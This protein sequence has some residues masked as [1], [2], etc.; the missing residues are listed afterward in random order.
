MASKNFYTGY[1]KSTRF[2]LYL[3]SSKDVANNRSLVKWYAYLEN[4]NY[5]YVNAIRINSVVVNGT[6]VCG[7]KT[8]SNYTSK[9]S[10]LLASGQLYVA[11][12]ADGNKQIS[13][14]I[15]GWL[16]SYGNKNA[17]GS[18]TL[19]SIPRATTPTLGA[20]SVSLGNAV[21]INTSPAV[22]SWTHTIKWKFGDQSGTIATK[23][24]AKSTSWTPPASL[25]SE[26]PDATTGTVT[27]TVE[28][29]NG[30]TLIGSKTINLKITVP[31]TS[32]TFKPT[33]SSVSMTEA[34]ESVTTMF[35]SI[36]VKLLSKVTFGITASGKYGSEIVAYK[37]VF[38]DVTYNSQSFTSNAIKASGTVTAT[39]TV[40]DSRGA[41][42]QTT[43]SITV[44]DY[45]YP[46]ITDIK[47]E[48]SGTTVKV[49]VK[50]KIAPVSNKNT[51]SL[52]VTYKKST[53]TTWGTPKTISLSAYDFS[54]T[55]VSTTITGIDPTVTYDI[56]AT[57]TDKAS[58]TILQTATGIT[59]ISILA[60]GKG[61]RFFGEAE[62][63]G[64]HVGNID[65][66]ITDDEYDELLSLLGGGI[67]INN[68]EQ[69]SILFASGEESNTAGTNNC[70][71]RTADYIAAKANAD[72]TVDI[73]NSI[74]KGILVFIYLFNSNK[75]IIDV[76]YST[77]K[78]V[79][80]KFTTT[81]DTAY[82]R[83]VFTYYPSTT[84]SPTDVAY[85]LDVSDLYNGILY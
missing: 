5:W 29:Y 19:D 65:Y 35:G 68:L 61:I 36:F 26:I 13:A 16:Y 82:L 43:K 41:T 51:R 58:T 32:A 14:S 22:S 1:A 38:D 52:I 60:G 25:A 63:E 56:K 71:V 72:Y 85:K 34:V 37:T 48:I 15:S 30:T 40:T 27:I 75:E 69:G 39:I 64:F 77:T 20:S 18:M 24:T 21:A 10:Y 70:R 50:G 8:F 11:H 46:A 76:I 55:G 57:L 47:T 4:G 79:P 81:S 6:T 42:Q 7:S 80:V 49:T 78:P 59:A 66:T 28:T 83:F 2:R 17:N 62:E 12:N 9:G 23:T 3:V 54:G 53:D 67:A 73:E 44:V 45:E 33:I 74:G 31:I 84:S